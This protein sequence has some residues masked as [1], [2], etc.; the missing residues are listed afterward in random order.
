MMEV[1]YT[2]ED[3]CYI[4]FVGGINYFLVVYWVIWL[5]NIGNVCFGC[6]INFIMEGEE[7][8]WCYYVVCD[9]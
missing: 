5:D 8:I 3:Y 4:V 6:S 9:F 1:M 7:G 2:G